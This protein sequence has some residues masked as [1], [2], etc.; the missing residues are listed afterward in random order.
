M[1]ELDTLLERG[2]L[3]EVVSHCRHIL[4]HFP[5]NADT[6][7]ILGNALL[8][9]GQDEN[10]DEHIKE[11]TQIFQ[12]LLSFF[13]N[14]YVAHLGLSEIRQRDAKLD[15]AIWHLERAYEQIP[16]S[17]P[18][19]QA[20]RELYVKRDGAGRA[21]EKIQLTRA[22]LARQ[23]INGQLFDQ[24]LIELRT[25]LQQT[26]ERIDL[27]V[28]L[29]ETLWDSQ[30][31]IEA[32]EEALKILKKLPK[33][34]P[35]NR[36]LARLWL[37]NER[38]TDAQTFLERVE[39][40]DPYA[41]AEVVR[42]GAESQDRNLIQRLDYRTQAQL[43]AASETPDWVSDLGDMGSKG[44]RIDLL[45]AAASQPSQPAA[46]ARTAVDDVPDWFSDL[47]SDFQ[48]SI[49][50]APSGPSQPTG[51]ASAV[52]PADMDWF[53]DQPA[54]QPAAIPSWFTEE[55][56]ALPTPQ[57]ADLPTW[58]ADEFEAQS[59]P[60]ADPFPSL[61][62]DWSAPAL[63]TSAAEQAAVD[64]DWLFSDEDD[65]AAAPSGPTAFS[66]RTESEPSTGF[67]GLLDEIGTSRSAEIFDSLQ[68]SEPVPPDWLAGFADDPFGAAPQQPADEPAANAGFSLDEDLFAQAPSLD[69]LA[70]Q[71]DFAWPSLDEQP[72]ESVEAQAPL[73]MDKMMDMDDMAFLAAFDESVPETPTELPTAAPV[74]WLAET[75]SSEEIQSAELAASAVPEW[76]PDLR[77]PDS[78]EQTA[79]SEPAVSGSNDWLS[80]LRAAADIWEDDESLSTDE[81]AADFE[82]ER[83]RE[84]APDLAPAQ[85][86]DWVSETNAAANLWDE[87]KTFYGFDQPADQETAPSQSEMSASE[88]EVAEPA[89]GAAELES[90]PNFWDANE[91]VYTFEAPSSEPAAAPELPTAEAGSTEIDDWMTDLESAN[92][93]DLLAELG[94]AQAQAPAPDLF[95]EEASESDQIEPA[96]LPDWVRDTLPTAGS[97][98]EI[99]PLP[100]VDE[101]FMELFEPAAADTPAADWPSLE[102]AEPEK[103]PDLDWLQ[104]AAAGDDWLSSFAAQPADTDSEAQ[105]FTLE[106]LAAETV[107]P[108]V[109]TG[110]L[111]S[112]WET[113]GRSSDEEVEA[114][115]E[116]A[117][118]YV[119][120]AESSAESTVVPS[121][122]SSEEVSLSQVQEP[123]I[124]EPRA[125]T[126][127]EP[128]VGRATS[129]LLAS[130]NQTKREPASSESPAWL[131]GMEVD[132]P[133]K[134]DDVSALLQ[135]PYDP[136]EGG[137]A[138]NV[139]KYQSAKDTGVLQ[140]DE[141][142][143][144]MRAFSGEELPEVDEAD[145]TQYAFEIPAEPE[146]QASNLADILAGQVSELDFETPASD[147]YYLETEDEEEEANAFESASAADGAMPDWLAA[148]TQSEV[149]KYPDLLPPAPEP[150]PEPEPVDMSDLF[151]SDT[152]LDWL[153]PMD[154]LFDSD[155]VESEAESA[156]AKAMLADLEAAL[157][158]PLTVEDEDKTAYAFDLD[159]DFSAADLL[160]HQPEMS[161]AGSDDLFDDGFGSLDLQG[162]LPGASDLDLE[163]A[164]P[165]DMS[166]TKRAEE[167]QD[168]SFSFEDED[169]P[170]S[171]SFE[172]YKPLWLRRLLRG[173]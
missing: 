77:A 17:Q 57:T 89:T 35:A 107:L 81:P 110:S 124:E 48:A 160:A 20:L 34:V 18:L 49:P 4:K 145:Q 85:T 100:V 95:A 44:N 108:P 47:G 40:I 76:L 118:E 5:Q 90:A 12:R 68:D 46:P 140:P 115:A 21:S 102:A 127:S 43:S 88:P 156:E 55:P 142:L 53:N 41:A 150:E 75:S 158:M 26:P 19:Q 120:E 30:H 56:G 159:N 135:Q 87:D 121:A 147:D 78:S 32:A 114:A 104:P 6:L 133:S 167:W 173:K 99:P 50:P 80:D 62:D 28:L 116:S 70:P 157:A 106:P 73:D 7:R 23:Y 86:S 139:P 126:P 119:E 51:S 98:A 91:T 33:C 1:N 24:A 122:E 42:P 146:P 172:E 11:S 141:R 134:T 14:D 153:K 163:V 36:I 16:G 96:E 61:D 111:S 93:M 8:Q 64:A 144:W 131:T 82:A 71:D 165:A 25:A 166:D 168:E 74:E 59:A 69:E 22:A 72:L 94:Q 105:E 63:A 66:D 123:E 3:T 117:I 92:D 169:V 113:A 143:D 130:L 65:I 13:P 161:S 171:F 31:P 45:Q 138:D 132:D 148:I 152:E 155:H 79:S 125:E 38:P 58:F 112:W 101:G 27:Q 15:Q 164:Q 136:F 170:D 97:Q 103:A 52:Q 109:D 128:P 54:A 37:D 29:A 151:A 2:A 39:A 83:P 10:V 154:Q 9:K 162:A 67:T 137:S 60:S 129:R 149:M 84:E